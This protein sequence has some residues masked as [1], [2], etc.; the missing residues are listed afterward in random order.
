MRRREGLILNQRLFGSEPNSAILRNCVADVRLTEQN[1]R[2]R[3]RVR[4]SDRISY[5]VFEIL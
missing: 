3:S 5:E 4:Q 1:C 2:H